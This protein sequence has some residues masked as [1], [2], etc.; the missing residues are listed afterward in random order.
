MVAAL[1]AELDIDEM[2]AAATEQERRVLVE[3]LVEEAIVYPD[4]LQV[5]VS[6]A[7][8]LNLR[9]SEMG[10]R[11]RRLLVSKGGLPPSPTGNDPAFGD[12]C[13]RVLLAPRRIPG[14]AEGERSQPM[15]RGASRSGGGALRCPLVFPRLFGSGRW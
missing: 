5:T 11:S 13:V 12:R 2:W 3:E 1:L 4:R 7:P 14:A 8:R 6:G 9:Y 15:S 10:L